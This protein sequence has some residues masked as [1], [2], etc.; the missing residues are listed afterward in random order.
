MHGYYSFSLKT[1]AH[2]LIVNTFKSLVLN[3][4]YYSWKKETYPLNRFL[5]LL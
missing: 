4:H 2:Y 1:R 3:T 5:L